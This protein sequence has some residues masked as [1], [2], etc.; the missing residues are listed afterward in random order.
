VALPEDRQ[1]VAAAAADAMER[2]A[3]DGRMPTALVGF[4]GFLDAIYD[5]VDRRRDMTPT[6]YE[7]I[8]T[9][10][11]FAS[12]VAA[13]AGRSA[14]IELVLREERFGG[15]GPLLASGLAALGAGVT[16]IGAVGGAESPRMLHPAYEPFTRRCRRVLPIA[17]TAR[18]DALEFDDGK[19]MFNHPAS[20]QEVTWDRLVEVVGLDGLI[21]AV[22]EADLIGIVNWTIVGGV[23]GIWEGLLREVLPRV[24]AAGKRVFIDLSDPAK[25][26]DAD[27]ARALELLTRLEELV[28]MTLGL[29]MAEAE[30]VAGVLGV[31]GSTPGDPDH[32][33]AE[34]LAGSI[35]RATGL[36]CVVVHP[37]HGAAAATAT[38][39]MW[40]DGPFTTA[41]RLSTGAGDHF[42]AG[43]ALAQ[44]LGLS[45]DRC[46]ASAC[47]VSGAYV[48]DAESPGCARV[49][50]FLR[51]LPGPETDGA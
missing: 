36:S 21:R 37:R 22:V 5:V 29:N 8:R 46:L 42:N 30:R 33:R 14:N 43:F 28:R 23:E 26:S 12:R 19:V 47:A 27:I 7:R 45:L 44:Q 49:I 10:S 39:C 16:Y 51:S 24:N 17:P 41:P 34:R 9:I 18:T 50:G 20:V 31:L 3:R 2:A 1:K 32:A 40:F 11:E 13:A 35:R 25:R 15:N 48:R 6:G 4:D 38:E